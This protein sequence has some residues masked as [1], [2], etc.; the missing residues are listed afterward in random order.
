MCLWRPFQIPLRPFERSDLNYLRL[1]N[2]YAIRLPSAC[3]LQSGQATEIRSQ[4]ATQAWWKAWP[5]ARAQTD[6]RR[7]TAPPSAGAEGTP[8]PPPP[9]PPP[10][11]PRRLRARLC[12]QS[13]ARA[14]GADRLATVAFHPTS[15]HH[16]E[17]HRT[18][19]IVSR[20]PPASNSQR[21]DLCVAQPAW[22]SGLARSRE[23]RTDSLTRTPGETH[24]DA[25]PAA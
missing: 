16:T 13:P 5:H 23:P 9:P 4:R 24:T 3:A 7:P 20:T 25:G 1:T 10:P 2:P 22:Q 17:A 8:P 11:S 19:V 15:A 12:L 18:H 14:P 21:A 6:S